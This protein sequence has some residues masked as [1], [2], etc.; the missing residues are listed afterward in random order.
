MSGVWGSCQAS[1]LLWLTLLI[2]VWLYLSAVTPNNVCIRKSSL[3]LPFFVFRFS[4]YFLLEWY[5]ALM[6][7]HSLCSSLLSCLLSPRAYW[8]ESSGMSCGMCFSSCYCCIFLY[9][10]MR[11][12]IFTYGISLLMSS[13]RYCCWSQTESSYQVISRSIM[14]YRRRYSYL[15]L[16][17]FL[18]N[19]KTNM[20]F[21]SW[22]EHWM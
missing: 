12:L 2:F 20:L 16:C 9:I 19:K 7:S 3:H 17:F 11:L 1:F 8:T 22:G 10:H 6:Q 15:V 21:V 4:P 13:I 14:K 18:W 5:I